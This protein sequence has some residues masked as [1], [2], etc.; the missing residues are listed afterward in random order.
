MPFIVEGEK[1]DNELVVA[2]C[3]HHR[4]LRNVRAAAEADMLVAARFEHL[5]VET[6]RAHAHSV[7]RGYLERWRW[8]AGEFFG[9]GN[10]AA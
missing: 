2:Q 1:L 10:I 5:G 4:W 9:G 7:L 3:D 8:E 6:E